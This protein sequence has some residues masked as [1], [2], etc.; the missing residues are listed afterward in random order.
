MIG[1]VNMVLSTVLHLSPFLR[2][3]CCGLCNCLCGGLCNCVCGG[4]CNCV[5]GGTCGRTGDDPCDGAFDGAHYV[6]C[7]G[8]YSSKFMEIGF[9]PS[10]YTFSAHL[11]CCNISSACCCRDR[12]R[13]FRCQT[14]RRRRLLR[15]VVGQGHLTRSTAGSSRPEQGDLDQLARAQVRGE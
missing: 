8:T 7:D 15:R 13:Q 1:S 12:R 4:L 2:G 10:T 3:D 6:A 11:V 5:C 14:V 9:L